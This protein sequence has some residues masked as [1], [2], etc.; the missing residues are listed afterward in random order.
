M[1]LEGN[2]RPAKDLARVIIKSTTCTIKKQCI[3]ILQEFC[4]FWVPFTSI[5]PTMMMLSQKA[6]MYCLCAAISLP[7]PTPGPGSRQLAS[8][9]RRSSSKKYLPLG[10]TTLAG[11]NP[12]MVII[13]ANTGHY[14]LDGFYFVLR[15]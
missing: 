8:V 14:L 4:K 3:Q 10:L 2:P 13:T 7:W 12:A 6:L 15:I 5:I 1:S 11:G 9:G